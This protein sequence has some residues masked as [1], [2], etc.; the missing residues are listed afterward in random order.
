MIDVL[1]AS[2]Q[3]CSSGSGVLIASNGII[4]TNFHVASRGVSYAIHLENCDTVFYTSELL[5]YHADD[6][7]ALIRLSGCPARPIP[8][9]TCLLYTSISDSYCLSWT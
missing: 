7:L 3:P 9:Y 6:D 1:D 4:L 5:K 8:L 2:G